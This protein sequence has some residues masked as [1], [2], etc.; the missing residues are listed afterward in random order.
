VTKEEEYE[1]LNGIEL[2]VKS[3]LKNTYIYSGPRYFQ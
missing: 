3:A 1:K 2:G